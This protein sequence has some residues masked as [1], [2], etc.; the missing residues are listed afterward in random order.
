MV[1]SWKILGT[2]LVALL[3]HFRSLW[4]SESFPVPLVF[5][6]ISG[7]AG[8]PANRRFRNFPRREMSAFVHTISFQQ[9]CQIFLGAKYQNGKKYEKGL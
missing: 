6:I 7:H 5:R 4:F 2:L 9:D 1:H 8:F 3:N